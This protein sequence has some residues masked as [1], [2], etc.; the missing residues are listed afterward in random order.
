MRKY[1]HI[2][3]NDKSVRSDDLSGEAVIRAGRNLIVRTM[4]ERNLAKVDPLSPE[5][6]LIFSAGPFAGT[7]FSNA[8]RISV[9]CKSPLTG[10][11]K[12]ANAGGTFAFAMGQLE[13]AGF[14][15]DGASDNWTLIR[16][17][18]DDGIIFEDATPY[19]GKSNF[20]L[21]ELLHERFGEKVS[22][23][24][25]GPVGEY[26]GLVAGISFSDNELR[27]VRL[28]ARGGVGAVMGSKKVK[29]IICDKA[30]MPPFADRK[31]VMS[32]VKDYGAKIRDDAG[33][34]SLSRNGTMQVADMTN[35]LGG[36][37]VNNFSSGQQ[38]DTSKEG[39]VLTMGGDYIRDLNN[40]RGG[41]HTHACMPGCQIKCSNVYVDKDG[42]EVVSPLEYETLCLLGTNVGITDPDDVARLN[43]TVNDL[44][45]D[46]IEVGAA[47]GI[48]MDTGQA[49]FGDVSFMAEA[50][51]DIRNGTERGRILSQGA[52]RVGEYYGSK[53][54]PVIKK[55]ALSAYDPR[56][57]EV[58][59]ISMMVTAQGA[60]HTVGNLPAAECAGKSTEE[61]SALSLEVQIN[62]AVADSLGLCVF[63]RGVTN[64]NHA[65]IIEAL[66]GAFDVDLDPDY[67]N[68]L[69]RETLL[70]EIEFNKKA[71]FTEED[72][73]LPQF[74]YDEGLPPTGKSARHFAPR[75]NKIQRK[76][77]AEGKSFI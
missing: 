67:M 19:L 4:L 1:L 54:V 32:L 70:M 36:M 47:L 29:A 72:D 28:A 13:I 69:G 51:E 17:T 56:V 27:P 66:N 76:L 74:F 12:E 8:N 23:A 14:T 55:Q 50:L 48:L 31:K 64:N 59:G 39:N 2:N 34:Q 26:S 30:K 65:E 40:G 45:C 68:A 41:E 42:N 35:H 58:T 38:V 53:R 52:A 49:E 6:P 77:L 43:E 7:S 11:I 60:D 3:L 75:I 18:R 24:L 44:G 37:P 61:L 21:A 57:I 20:E 62:S 63:G 5:N 33:A 71:G 16:I 15:L 46:T 9:G 25:C 22:L 10:G 73:V